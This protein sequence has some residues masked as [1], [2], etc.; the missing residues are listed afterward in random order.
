MPALTTVQI[1][2][3]RGNLFSTWI[4]DARAAEEADNSESEDKVESPTPISAST[5][6]LH[7]EKSAKWA[8]T[9]LAVLFGGAPKPVRKFTPDDIDEEAE[10]M[11]ALADAEEEARLDD[12]GVI[13]LNCQHWLEKYLPYRGVDVTAFSLSHNT[14]TSCDVSR[15][16]CDVS[17]GSVVPNLLDREWQTRL[18][19]PELSEIHSATLVNNTH[20]NEICTYFV[21]ILLLPAA[22]TFSQDNHLVFK[23]ISTLHP[24]SPPSSP[25]CGT[26]KE[27]KEVAV[28]SSDI[29]LRIALGNMNAPPRQAAA[30]KAKRIQ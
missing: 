14:T 17:T 25:S 24:L 10:L 15:P 4:A 12:G 2:R 28:L 19:T 7:R 3:P 16:V 9:T 18:A 13:S 6:R 11:E 22:I 1:G 23:V 27:N 29:D 20:M 5:S 30:A 21:S 8:K 26:N